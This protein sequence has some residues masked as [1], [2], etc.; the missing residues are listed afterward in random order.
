MHRQVNEPRVLVINAYVNEEGTEAPI[1]QIHSDATTL[2]HY[3]VIHEHNRR[4]FGQFID[5]TTGL[6]IYG[7][8]WPLNEGPRVER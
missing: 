8:Q 7:A 1:V 3:R 2:E 6:Q 4:A 5:A